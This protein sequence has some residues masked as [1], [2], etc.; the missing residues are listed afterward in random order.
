MPLEGSD[1]PRA[2]FLPTLRVGR[3]FFDFSTEWD[4]STTK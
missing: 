3:T 2:F 1:L 4:F